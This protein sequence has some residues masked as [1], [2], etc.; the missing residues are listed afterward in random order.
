MMMMNDDDDDDDDEEEEED[1]DGDGDDYV[2]GD[3]AWF[4]W[5]AMMPFYNLEEWAPD[6]HVHASRRLGST[7][8]TGNGFIENSNILNSSII[9]KFCCYAV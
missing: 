1:N 5:I 2:D 4:E 7:P 6:Q 3:D 8:S 9:F